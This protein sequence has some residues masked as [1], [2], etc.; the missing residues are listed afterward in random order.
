MQLWY[1]CIFLRVCS[2]CPVTR[3]S[4]QTSPN[5]VWCRGG[6][7]WQ[8][9][10]RRWVVKKPGASVKSV[11]GGWAIH[12]TGERGKIPEVSYSSQ[13]LFSLSL[14]RCRNE[15]NSTARYTH[16]SEEQSDFTLNQ[17]DSLVLLPFP[18][19]ETKKENK[20]N[21]FNQTLLLCFLFIIIFAL[22][23]YTCYLYIFYAANK[24]LICDGTREANQWTE[25]EVDG[26]FNGFRLWLGTF[27]HRV[28][29]NNACGIRERGRIVGNWYIEI[30]EAEA[31]R[32]AGCIMQA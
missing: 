32:G 8:R 20:L 9:V 19:S 27:G 3:T 29:W 10:A 26:R 2:R 18:Q 5:V 23:L 4:P 28:L 25:T 30:A 17:S 16:H 24:L 11:K 13:L 21:N 12:P 1:T 6:V 22:F 14:C 31:C 15:R 7:G